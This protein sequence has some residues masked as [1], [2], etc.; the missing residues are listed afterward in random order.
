MQKDVSRWI[1]WCLYPEVVNQQDKF[2]VY[3]VE[4]ILSDQDPITFPEKDLDFPENHLPWILCRL[5]SEA[6]ASLK[7]LAYTNLLSQEGLDEC[8]CAVCNSPDTLEMVIR[9]QPH[10]P[11]LEKHLENQLPHL[12]NLKKLTNHP[13]LGEL[14]TGRRLLVTTKDYLIDNFFLSKDDAEEV[15]HNSLKTLKRSH[16]L[17]KS[18]ETCS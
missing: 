17:A 13:F 10:N 2:G 14:V 6:W 7:D 9:I 5:G 3:T 4:I 11:D 16:D 12:K 18:H 8:F 1:Q 15:L